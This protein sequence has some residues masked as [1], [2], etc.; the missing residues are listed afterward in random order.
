MPSFRESLT[1]MLTTWHLPFARECIDELLDGT[2]ART[3]TR[4]PGPAKGATQEP[5]AHPKSSSPSE[6]DV[7]LEK[8]APFIVHGEGLPEHPYWPTPGSGITWGVGWD[9]S[10]QTRVKLD[11]DWVDL[12]M[13]DRNRLAAA[14]GGDKV[15]D[16][17]R[18]LLPT[19]K[20]ITVPTAASIVMFKRTMLPR[21]YR[22]TLQAFPGVDSLPD[23]VQV[24]LIS[25]VYNRG[26]AMINKKGQ[27]PATL[28]AE[29]AKTGRLDRRYEM[30]RIREDV[31]A[32]NIQGIADQLRAMERIW[33]HGK[34]AKG[35]TNRRESEAEMVERGLPVA[36]SGKR[37]GP[38]Q[39]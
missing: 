1:S 13:A 11:A 21:Y 2:F 34:S 18:D 35:M 31:A 22:M 24:A 26:K 28:D 7:V 23:P 15:G 3:K 19:L 17:A 38:L 36:S 27:D 39:P 8:A 30:R 9:A 5:V 33:A 16:A 25:L 32:K 37:A 12:P 6:K 10:Q 20:D 29:A 4:P 14:L